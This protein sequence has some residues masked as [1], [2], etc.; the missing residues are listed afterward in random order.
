MNLG[1]NGMILCRSE[2]KLL[3][4]TQELGGGVGWWW[5]SLLGEP[6]SQKSAC[7]EG[8]LELVVLSWDCVLYLSL[9]GRVCNIVWYPGISWYIMSVMLVV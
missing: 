7:E 5:Q 3:Q 4:T 1:A 6:I 2:P 9:L 8:A